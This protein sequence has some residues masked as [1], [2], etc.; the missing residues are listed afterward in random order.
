MGLEHRGVRAPHLRTPPRRELTIS[1]RIAR[2]R[3]NQNDSGRSASGDNQSQRS[4]SES[5]QTGRTRTSETR[6]KRSESEQ[7]RPK[8]GSK[9]KPA[10]GGSR[11][12]APTFAASRNPA[13]AKKNSRGQRRTGDA[14]QRDERTQTTADESVN[15][16]ATFRTFGL[17]EN[18]MRGISELGFEQ[19][20]PIQAKTIPEAMNGRDVLGLAQ[21]GTGKTAAFALPIL[22]R[23]L[24]DRRQ[25]P[26]AL[27]VA[28]T[29]E[30]AIQIHAEILELGKFTSI[31]A[32][33]IFGGVSQVKQVRA[34]RGRPDILIACPGRLLDLYKQNECDLSRI[35]TLV[36]DEADHMFDMGFLPDIR[37][38]ITALPKQR[39]NLL[40]SATMPK[41]IRGLADRILNRPHVVELNHSKPA[42]TIEHFLYPVTQAKKMD[43]LSQILH[44]DSFTSAIVFLRTKHRARKIARDLDRDGHRAIALQGNM[45]QG[46][47]DRAMSGF[48]EGRYDILV[49]TDIAARGIDVANISHVVNFDLPGTPDAYTHRIGRTGRSELTG[50][51]I[52]FVTSEDAAGVRA[53]ERNLGEEIPRRFV[54]GF[55]VSG[56]LDGTSPKSFGSKKPFAGGGRRSG[57][58]GRPSAKP[59]AKAS[60]GVKK[61][62]SK[63]AN[64]TPW[65]AGVAEALDAPVRTRRAHRPKGSGP[66]RSRS[67]R[68]R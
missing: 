15:S 22:E 31:K 38:I 57:G 18:L 61:T 49:A 2:P 4:L 35:E 51:A 34:L 19:P 59:G 20:R 43:L 53:I 23:L 10:T 16:K 63:P 47:R 6:A 27:I 30:L 65:G 39:Q 40:F 58:S 11:R 14:P 64:T 54:K 8:G 5:R 52:T 50:K 36:L 62:T 68:G 28:P 9:K 7:G 45:S 24:A 33:T 60:F 29:R 46:Q 26:R 55:A 25:G 12:G 56:I 42:S 48:R 44:E 21:T 17:S 66:G 37:R 32:A 1:N 67:R 13:E 3:S 41:E